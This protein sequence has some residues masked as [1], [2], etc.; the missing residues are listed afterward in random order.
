[1]NQNKKKVV[2][3]PD[4]YYSQ[5]VTETGDDGLTEIYRLIEELYKMRLIEKLAR[6]IDKR[7]KESY[8]QAFNQVL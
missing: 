6:P 8:A 4:R 5:E 3:A 2:H 7:S 1:M